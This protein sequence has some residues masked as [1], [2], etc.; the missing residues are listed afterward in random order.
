MMAIKNAIVISLSTVLLLF[1]LL[2]YGYSSNMCEVDLNGTNWCDVPLADG[3]NLQNM[4][5]VRYDPSQPVS[6]Q[7]WRGDNQL[8]TGDTYIHGESLVIILPR[9]NDTQAVVEVGSS[10]PVSFDTA[11]HVSNVSMTCCS[12]FRFALTDVDPIAVMTIASNITED[13][14]ISAAW[15]AGPG[16]VTLTNSFILYHDA[17]AA[18]QPKTT[19]SNTSSDT[20]VYY[21]P[22]LLTLALIA[23][24]VFAYVCVYRRKRAA[25]DDASP[26]IP[27]KFG[28]SDNEM[29]QVV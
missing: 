15:S 29:L 8:T 16:A 2:S 5:I 26:I 9:A 3:L 6:I 13:I 17:Q 1:P 4:G 7:V 27:P 25:E 28:H 24:A 12:G 18:T 11:S 22:I 23:G 14:I 21:V 20:S 10:L 19:I